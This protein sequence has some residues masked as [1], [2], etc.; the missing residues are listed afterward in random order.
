MNE[1][2]IQDFLAN[3]P[4][5]RVVCVGDVMLDRFLYGKVSRVSPEAPVP[6]VHVT[7]EIEMLGGAGNVV[8]N[9]T[10]LG[11]RVDFVSIIGTDHA[12]T[13]VKSI[14]QDQPTVT[15]FLDEQ[16][17]QE[18]TVKTRVIAERQ[19]I[20]RVDRENSLSLSKAQQQD[21]LKTIEGRLRGANVLILSDYGKGIFDPV[22]TSKII[23]SA[24]KHDVPVIVDPKS[25]NYADYGG[26]TFIT[27]NLK[28]FQGACGKNVSTD[29]DIYDE[30]RLLMGKHAIHGF[31]VTRSQDGMSLIEKESDLHISTQAQEVFDV[32]GAGD[33]VIALFALALAAGLVPQDAARLANAGA[34]VVVS[35]IGTATVSPAE[36]Q[37]A[38]GRLAALPE[39]DHHAHPVHPCVPWDDA[40]KKVLQWKADGKTVGFTNGCF[41]I[42]HPGHT[43]LLAQAKAQCD[44]LV[45]GLNSDASVKRLKGNSRPINDQVARASVLSALKSIDMVVVFDQDTPLELIQHLKPSLLVKGSDYTMDQVVGAKEVVSWGGRVV[46]LD[47]VPGHSTTNII[48]RLGGPSA[49]GG[50]S[51]TSKK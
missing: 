15:A 29:E 42:L 49:G 51:V 32:S 13:K 27:P 31:L 2:I 38:V 17:H 48:N 5:L 35:K 37:A 34:G 18:T 10:A 30:A 9:I 3:V 23:A 43:A 50:G 26:A 20:V 22:L 1:L 14:L 28:E 41:D 33:T 44:V 46:L 12:G 7:Q 47:L 25:T 40:Q 16:A 39:H 11:A 36:L 8:Q 45:L 21:L 19:Q 4:T 6:V 24:K